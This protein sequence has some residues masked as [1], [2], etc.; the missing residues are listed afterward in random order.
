MLILLTIL[1]IIKTLYDS[2]NQRKL[3][4]AIDTIEVGQL[5]LA[6]DEH[7]KNSRE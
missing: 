4:A 1:L 6:E 3:D 7:G 2:Y 5:I